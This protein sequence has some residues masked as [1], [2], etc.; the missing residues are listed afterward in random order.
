MKKLL[1]LFAVLIVV[2]VAFV[3]LFGAA[4][5]VAESTST[6]A[7]VLEDLQRDPN[8]DASEY[9]S[10]NSGRDLSLITIAETSDQQ[11]VLYVYQS[12]A[13]IKYYA[14]SVRMS[15][16]VSDNQFEDTT[17]YS[18]RCLDRNGVFYKYLVIGYHVSDDPVRHYNIVQLMRN[19]VSGVD[20]QSR[21]DNSINAVPY[22]V[23]KQFV[24]EMKD[25]VL[26]NTE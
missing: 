7:G 2:C 1:V 4:V 16:R 10:C 26:T 6:E 14:K 21:Y 11:L 19:F 22:I 13:S 5:A 12:N 17:D 8:F 9:P 24:F 20:A 25:G 23:S 18:L 15:T 3:P